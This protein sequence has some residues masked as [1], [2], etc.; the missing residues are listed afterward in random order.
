[1]P[2]SIDKESEAGTVNRLGPGTL[3]ATTK[4]RRMKTCRT[5]RL[6]MAGLLLCPLAAVLGGPETETARELK[7]LQAQ[8]EKAIA[9]ALEPI[10]ARFQQSL[11]NLSRHALQANDVDTALMIKEVISTLPQV[12]AQ[13]LAGRWRLVANNGYTTDVVLRTDGTGTRTDGGRF[14][15]HIDGTTLYL[16][17]NLTADK[18]QLPIKDGKLKGVNNFDNALTLTRMK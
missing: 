7:Q 4:K 3:T 16:D 5:F 11:E 15:W 9:A 17:P 12:A 10:N 2:A 18:F 8:H 13:E 6:F 14:Q 1:M